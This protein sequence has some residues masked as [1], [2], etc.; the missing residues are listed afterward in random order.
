MGLFQRLFNRESGDD[1]EDAPITLDV[2]RRRVQLTRLMTALDELADRMRTEHTTDDPGWRGRV[3]EY[4]RL[5]GEAMNLRPAPT[6]EALLDLVF[7]IRPV[8][9]GTIPD[10]FADLAPLQDEVMAAAEDLRQL[11]PGE[12]S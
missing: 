6:R 3:N 5:A 4:T 9:S 7:A 2:E 12:K 8:F 1:V 10:G 11:L